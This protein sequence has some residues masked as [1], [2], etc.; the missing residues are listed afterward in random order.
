MRLPA[1]MTAVALTIIVAAFWSGSNPTISFAREG[2]TLLGSLE[3]WKYP[4]SQMPQGASMSDG[5]NPTI[6][7]VKLQAI[8]TTADS[9]EQ[10]VEFY[11]KKLTPAAVADAPKTDDAA[12]PADAKSVL[13]QDDSQGRPIELKVFSVHKAD[14]STTLVISRAKDEKETHIAWSQYRRFELK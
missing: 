14:A 11:T 9:F 7:S 12:K 8:L 13:N 10:V 6:P 1:I 4:G 2:I 3:E 5:G